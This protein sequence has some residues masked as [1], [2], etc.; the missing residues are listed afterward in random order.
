MGLSRHT[1]MLLSE[2][3]W[4]RN[5]SFYFTITKEVSLRSKRFRESSTRKLGREQKKE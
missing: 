5:G 1:F 2:L 3:H 4:L